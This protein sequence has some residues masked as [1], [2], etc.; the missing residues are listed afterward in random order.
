MACPTALE[1]PDPPPKEKKQSPT[2]TPDASIFETMDAAIRPASPDDAGT[3]SRDAGADRVVVDGGVI[4]SPFDGGSTDQ[5]SG[6]FSES[7]DA[8]LPAV[9]ALPDAGDGPIDSGGSSFNTIVDAGNSVSQDMDA[10]A[11]SF[12]TTAD[13][14]LFVPQ[15]SDAG[16]PPIVD[17]L[18]NPNGTAVL[19]CHETC[20][21]NAFVDHCGTCVGGGT[22]LLACEQDCNEE[23][24]GHAFIDA[25]GTCVG[26]EDLPCHPSPFD[27]GYDAGAPQSHTDGGQWIDAGPTFMLDAPDASVNIDAGAPQNFTD[28]GLPHPDAGS[29]L[30]TFDAGVPFFETDAGVAVVD[31]AACQEDYFH[32]HLAGLF[33]RTCA[34]CH[35]IDG[36]AVDQ[37]ASFVLASPYVGKESEID[38]L[39]FQA[40]QNFLNADANNAS[41]L[42]QKPTSTLNHGGGE[43]IQENSEAEFALLDFVNMVSDQMVCEPSDTPALT[44]NDLVLTHHPAA[45]RSAA[46][47]L[48]DTLPTPEEVDAITSDLDSLDPALD[49]IMSSPAYAERIAIIYEDALLTNT[50]RSKNNSL[51]LQKAWGQ[52]TD[53]QGNTRGRYQWYKDYATYPQE[54]ER[55]LYQ[56]LAGLTGHG[57]SR[58]AKELVKHVITEQKDFGEILT[59]DYT[60]MNIYSAPVYE[61]ED[62]FDGGYFADE[63]YWEEREAGFPGLDGGPVPIPPMPSANRY[64]FKPVTIPAPVPTAGLLSDINFLGTWPTNK[65]NLNRSRSREVLKTFL[66]TDI[67]AQVNRTPESFAADISNPTYNDP[68]CVSCHHLMDPI[69]GAFQN[70]PRFQFQALYDPLHE[71]AQSRWADTDPL[72][73]LLPPGLSRSHPVPP[74]RM[75]DSLVWLA[76]NLVDDPRFAA[77]T[78]RVIFEGLSGRPAMTQ[79]NIEDEDFLQQQRAY[80]LQRQYFEELEDAFTNSG[81]DLNTM[82]KAMMKSPLLRAS[83]FNN[84][85]PYLHEHFGLHRMLTPEGLERKLLAT[86]GRKWRNYFGRVE[87]NNEAN[88]HWGF[89]TDHPHQ[90]LLVEFRESCGN[91]GNGCYARWYGLLGG[92]NIT[93]SGGNSRR[94]SVE[95]AV[96]NGVLQRMAAEIP[97]RVVPRDFAIISQ[98]NGLFE[99]VLFP[100]VDL[101]TLP[102]D[103]NGD[104]DVA[105]QNAIKDNLIYLAQHLWG[106]TLDEQDPEIAAA[107]DLFVAALALQGPYLGLGA[108]FSASVEQDEIDFKEAWEAANGITSPQ[109]REVTHDTHGTLR[110]WRMVID[111]FISDYHFLHQSVPPEGGA[112]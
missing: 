111:Y 89:D 15:T 98:T 108:G 79:P 17:C 59:A 81:R 38:A 19:D 18:G 63:S 27:A 90:S 107:Y 97:W 112:P 62:A 5:D 51:V 101:D 49:R 75:D 88:Y 100:Y 34:M 53:S 66:N 50:Y 26:G 3:I 104:A 77:A 16:L 42:W 46:L 95:N 44:T 4:S 10:G 32:D 54:N 65:V 35:T 80:Q 24:G 85:N 41:L 71:N 78:V 39:N 8:P 92:Q 83:H 55:D 22:G 72:V 13:A 14:G 6:L 109:R 31:Q 56:E 76:E 102:T 7:V 57:F 45:L 12:N 37:G 58:S 74:E 91:G 61:R 69:A 93:P 82:V 94:L 84:D 52:Q 2:T 9:S 36:I 96:F 87:P 25:C 40:L 86:T 23:W 11:S 60:M 33:R 43:Q 20:A 29:P 48:S 105:N 21:G 73:Q 28:A 30:T 99:R 110:A 68:T 1:D 70:W 103:E 47:L 67:L 106:Q 64:Y